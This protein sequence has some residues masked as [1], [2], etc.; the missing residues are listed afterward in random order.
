MN[1][2]SKI[3]AAAATGTLGGGPGEIG[4]W[5]MLLNSAIVFLHGSRI[6]LRSVN[7]VET[8]DCVVIDFQADLIA[9]VQVVEKSSPLDDRLRLLAGGWA[10]FQGRIASMQINGKY[11][12]R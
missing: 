4:C 11:L 9:N 3:G 5:R 6:P 2:S 10:I 8:V 7:Q 1:I 12:K